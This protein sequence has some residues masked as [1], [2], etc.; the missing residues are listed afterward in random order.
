MKMIFL[1]AGSGTRLYPYTKDK[2]KWLLSVRG[3]AILQYLVACAHEAGVTEVVVVRGSKGGRVLSPSVLYV[4]DL[5]GFNMVHSLFKAEAHLSEDVVVSYADILYEPGVLRRLLDSDAAVS[6]VVDLEWRQYYAARTDDPLSI[7]ESLVLEGDHVVEIGQPIRNREYP[8]GQYIG[9]VK[10]NATGTKVLR[11]VYHDLSRTYC[12]QPWRNAMRFENAYM[13]DLIQELLE[14]GVDVRAVLIHGGWLEFDTVL[15]YEGVL[16]WETSGVLPRFLSVNQ[17]PRNPSVLCAGAVVVGRRENGWHVLLVGD[18]T[19]RGWRFPKG[20]QEPGESIEQTAVRAVVEQIGF[21]PTIL[22]Y[23]N[24][25]GWTYEYNGHSWDGWT[26]FYLMRLLHGS[27]LHREVEFKTAKWFPMNQ[28]EEVLRCDSERASL[29][30]AMA[31]LA[32]HQ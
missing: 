8:C 13:T 19:S 27:R 9:L 7:A 23:V 5:D 4:D 15:D 2:P 17:L 16:E 26:Y 30:A 20:M 18:G 11:E 24:R 21:E 28:A 32:S 29:V 31:I 25:R 1:G 14:R 6:V 10:F 12:G 3:I 22:Q